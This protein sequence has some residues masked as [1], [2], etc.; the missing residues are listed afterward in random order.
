MAVFLAEMQ[1]ISTCRTSLKQD[2]IVA[3][4]RT[5]PHFK[6]QALIGVIRA[7]AFGKVP[8]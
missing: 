2:L 7:A 3:P 1:V 5:N 4:C 6:S 8:R